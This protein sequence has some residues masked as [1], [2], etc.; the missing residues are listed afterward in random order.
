MILGLMISVPVGPIGLL[1]LRRTAQRGLLTGLATGLGAATADA[2]FGG[3]AAFGIAAILDWVTGWQTEITIVGGLILLGMAWA[4]WHKQTRL[5]ADAAAS[6]MGNLLKA[7]V[8]G[9][10]LTCSNPVTIIATLAVVATLGGKMTHSE[11]SI[12]TAGVF[13]GASGWWL[14]LCGGVAVFRKMFSEKTI[15]YINH[16]TGVLLFGIAIFALVTGTQDLI[17]GR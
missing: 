3:V 14:A 12:L 2:I 4:A 16:G 10:A 15:V 9:F 1:C 13:V 6:S 5:E 11:A 17:A 8:T 7:Y